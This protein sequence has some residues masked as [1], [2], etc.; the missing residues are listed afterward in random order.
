MDPPSEVDQRVIY[1]PFFP[2]PP[3]RCL[4][5]GMSASELFGTEAALIFTHSAGGGLQA[6]AMK[7]FTYGFTRT[8]TLLAFQGNMSL[9]SRVKM[10]TAVIEAHD[11]FRNDE[12]E[13]NP[14]C[15]GG[16]SMGA[17]AAVMAATKETTHL[18]LASY[19]LHTNKEVRDQILLS[20][21]SSVKVLFISGDRDEMC[22]LQRLEYVRQHMKSKT[23]RIVVAGA[24]HGMNV[25]SKRLTR[26]L[27]REAGSQVPAWLSRSDD[28]LTEGT[29]S[30][31]PDEST[32]DWSGWREAKDTSLASSE[33]TATPYKKR[34]VPVKPATE[35]SSRKRRTSIRNE[36][37]N[38]QSSKPKS[39]RVRKR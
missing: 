8:S 30:L 9:V 14:T 2:K 34:P 6:D 32:I 11:M 22:D 13:I 33:E 21:P 18:I 35:K 27:G 3:I 37:D 25:K 1:V 7:N 20:L 12:I 26:L 10:F 24:D 19:P 15:L 23:W 4:Y 17:R 36:K 5:N 29:I 39:K 38:E 16:R 28:N 31:N